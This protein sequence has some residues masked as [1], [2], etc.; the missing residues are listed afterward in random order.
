MAKNILVVAPLGELVT[1][2]SGMFPPQGA[3]GVRVVEN[4]KE[5]LSALQVATFH[6]LVTSLRI[7][8]LS[9]GYR[10][11]AQIVGK[12]MPGDN[13]VVIVD[14]VTE[15]IR[16]DMAFL[17]LPHLRGGDDIDG[18]VGTVLD[19]LGAGP[20]IELSKTAESGRQQQIRSFPLS[21]ASEGEALR[22]HWWPPESKVEEQITGLGILAGDVVTVV[23]KQ[24]G[25]ALLVERN[26]IRYALG[27]GIT[28]KIHV[29]KE[30]LGDL[31]G[32]VALR[33]R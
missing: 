6:L 30:E 3:V 2:L 19:K 31:P 9:D 17:G 18:I 7:P 16:T 25:G 32:E 14:R 24:P 4:R 10:L 28:H 33:S 26:G 1:K 20:G 8:G 21:L 27:V 15:K 12:V 22:V 29:V 11:L 23:R 5:A 13:I